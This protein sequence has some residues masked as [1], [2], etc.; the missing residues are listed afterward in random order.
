[1]AAELSISGL[2]IT[3]AKTN[4]PSKNI[5]A[6]S[7]TPSVAGTQ[8]MDN[9]QSVGTIEEAILLGDVA[10]GG[11]WF[12]QNM[13]PINFVQLRQATGAAAFCKLLAGEWACFRASVDMTAPFAIAD[14]GAC[15]VRFM[16]FDL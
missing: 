5:R 2:L 13:D 8:I 12:V 9:V 16:M 3:F 11:Y 14:T 7:F 4:V 15:N 10:P 6:D 1:M